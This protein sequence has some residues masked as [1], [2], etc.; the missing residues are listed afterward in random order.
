MAST[1]VV[2]TA[3]VILLTVYITQKMH[4]YNQKLWDLQT[5]TLADFS[6]Q[7]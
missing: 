6:V 5:S 3:L 7:F 2:F 1:L 4:V